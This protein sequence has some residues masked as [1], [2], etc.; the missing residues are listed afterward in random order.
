[1]GALPPSLSEKAY[2][3]FLTSFDHVELVISFHLVLLTQMNLS[4]PLNLIESSYR[5]R[6]HCEHLTILNRK[7]TAFHLLSSLQMTGET[8]RTALPK[9]KNIKTFCKVSQSH[10]RL[11]LYC[12]IILGK[13]LVGQPHFKSFIGNRRERERE[14]ERM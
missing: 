13:Y 12:K 8:S 7:G 9:N 5:A 10:V 14:R 6:V 1:M 4:H 3:N 11:P 2:L